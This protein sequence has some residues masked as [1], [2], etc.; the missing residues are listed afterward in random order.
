[1]KNI[2]GKKKKTAVLTAE[3]INRKTRKHILTVILAGIILIAADTVLCTLNRPDIVQSYG[4]L[5]IIRPESGAKS[6]SL[7]LQ[8]Q[9][10]GKQNIHQE[11]LNIMLKP[12]E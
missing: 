4:Q 10:E 6:S 12:Y 1:M 2:T 3:Q 8:A 9:I 11:K 5:Y 7:T